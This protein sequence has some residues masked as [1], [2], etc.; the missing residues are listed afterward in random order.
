[1]PFARNALVASMVVSGTFWSF[2]R[3]AVDEGGTAAQRRF[4]FRAHRKREL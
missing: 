1:M 2:R 3:R 4:W